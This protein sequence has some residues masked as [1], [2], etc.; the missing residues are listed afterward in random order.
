MTSEKRTASYKIISDA[1]GNIYKFFCDLSG[2][3]V[4]TASPKS[5][6]CT[7]EEELLLAWESEGKQ[8]FNLCRKCGRLVIDAMFNPDVL[9][10]V[11]CTPIEEYSDYCPKCGVK[12]SDFAYFCHRCGSVLL[13]GGK[14]EKDET[15][16]CKYY[17]KWE[18]LRKKGLNYYINIKY[19]IFFSKYYVNPA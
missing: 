8:H 13:Y 17:I 2:A 6:A 19:I 16:S 1:G 9:T 12:T 7:P 11:K 5:K 10:C 18:I 15:V 14:N 3:L 4:C